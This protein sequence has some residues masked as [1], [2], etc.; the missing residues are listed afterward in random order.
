MVN[1]TTESS[2]SFRHQ[3]D[4]AEWLNGRSDYHTIQ[5]RPSLRYNGVNSNTMVPIDPNSKPS[6]DGFHS[7][8]MPS[9]NTHNGGS[10]MAIASPRVAVASTWQN[11]SAVRSAGIQ[12]N[13]HLIQ[14]FTQNTPGAAAAA[15]LGSLSY[16]IASAS[17][18]NSTDHKIA[19][20][21]PGLPSAMSLATIYN[22]GPSFT[23]T[24][25]GNVAK[26][27]L[28]A[29]LQGPLADPGLLGSHVSSP[30]SGNVCF[31]LQYPLSW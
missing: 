5:Q 8:A 18:G 14:P 12:P 6:N 15:N 21:S 20:H 9:S 27:G 2:G 29:N 22:G 26:Q 17:V 30:H 11:N 4:N 13:T 23:N 28:P 16:P 10:N 1:S 19:T 25:I 7:T 3:V 24:N 31:Y